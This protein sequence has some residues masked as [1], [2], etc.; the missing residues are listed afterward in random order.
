[1]EAGGRKTVAWKKP[2][3]PERIAQGRGV[4]RGGH[5]HI[6]RRHEGLWMTSGNRRLPGHQEEVA[7]AVRIEGKD[8]NRSDRR[9]PA[10]V[11]A[12]HCMGTAART[13]IDC[14]RRVI[15]RRSLLGFLSAASA[16]LDRHEPPRRYGSAVQPLP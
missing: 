14:A 7:V 15:F 12:E 8:K 6:R 9:H 2:Q 1:M 4:R 10:L 13:I 11:K 16:K 5:G 3:K